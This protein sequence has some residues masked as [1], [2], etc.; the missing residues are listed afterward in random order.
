MGA[1]RST[2]RLDDSYGMS[3]V[4]NGLNSSFRSTLL[5]W[6]VHHHIISPGNVLKVT[7]KHFSDFFSK[8]I[9]SMFQNSFIRIVN[10]SSGIGH[11]LLF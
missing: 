8:Q 4:T 3:E 2:A 6:D 1:S 9:R 5:I 10:F 11:T 7:L